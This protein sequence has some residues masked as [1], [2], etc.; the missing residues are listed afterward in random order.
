MND[1]EDEEVDINVFL[2]DSIKDIQKN[3]NDT[4][5]FLMHILEKEDVIME[6]WEKGMEYVNNM[7]DIVKEL[8]K[9]I[10]GFK[11]KAIK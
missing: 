5:Q 11:P 4:Q 7:S 1:I 2:Q 6:E 10:R 8:K 3:L 9:T